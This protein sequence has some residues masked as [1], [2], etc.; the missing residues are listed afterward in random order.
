VAP[1]SLESGSEGDVEESV[2]DG[3]LAETVETRVS[4]DGV[5]GRD[6]FSSFLGEADF[7]DLR[8]EQGRSESRRKI[9]ELPLAGTLKVLER[10][11]FVPA[12]SWEGE[13]FSA[14]FS[15]F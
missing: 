3:Q 8:Q 5:R 14:G 6:G 12:S 11:R 1:S 15:A 4:R 9:A 2:H 7:S 10:D 13:A